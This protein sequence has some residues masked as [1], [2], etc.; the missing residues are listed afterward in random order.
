MVSS[1]IQGVEVKL[2]VLNQ[3]KIK[4]SGINSHLRTSCLSPRFKLEDVGV[5]MSGSNLSSSKFQMTFQ[6]GLGL[7]ANLISIQQTQIGTP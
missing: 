5:I 7:R 6:I 1:T 2:G 3:Q 4:I